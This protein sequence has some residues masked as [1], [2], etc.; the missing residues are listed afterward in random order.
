MAVIA[1]DERGNVSCYSFRMRCSITGF[2]G[3]PTARTCLAYMTTFRDGPLAEGGTGQSLVM[4]KG[5]NCDIDAAYA[6]LMVSS[7]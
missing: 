6:I 4:T 1:C 7:Y 5:H 2:Y 3:I